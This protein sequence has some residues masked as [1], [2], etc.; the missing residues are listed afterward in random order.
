MATN[1]R[2]ATA[3]AKRL[4]LVPAEEPGAAE[5]AAA[6]R[7]RSAQPDAPRERKRSDRFRQPMKGLTGAPGTRIAVCTGAEVRDYAKK[8]LVKLCFVTEDDEAGNL[9]VEVPDP[10]T[11]GCRY[12]RLVD[13]VETDRQLGSS[14]DPSDVFV[15]GRFEILVGYRQTELPNG[16]GRARRDFML[17]KKDEQDFLRVVDIIEHLGSIHDEDDEK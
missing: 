9:W 12:L 2:T 16:K 6:A 15:D 11:D 8:S 10:L 17:K 7:H 1:R 4:E 3:R 13:I 14:V 5:P